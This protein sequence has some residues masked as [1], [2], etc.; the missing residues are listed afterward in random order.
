MCFWNLSRREVN[1]ERTQF[2]F[3]ETV[4]DDIAKICAEKIR[5]GALRP[6]VESFDSNRL[7][8]MQD[9]LVEY[10]SFQFETAESLLTKTLKNA[11]TAEEFAKAL[12][13]TRIRCD[14]VRNREVKRIVETLDGAGE[15]PI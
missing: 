14:Q 11:T 1:Q 13:P 9:F 5:I 6:E 8:T 7:Q 15:T 3:D 10:P 4:S 12:I 2:N